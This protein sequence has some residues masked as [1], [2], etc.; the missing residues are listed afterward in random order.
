MNKAALFLIV[1]LLGCE[2]T[3]SEEI[4]QCNGSVVELLNDDQWV[5][6]YDCAEYTC[7]GQNK[8]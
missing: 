5:F 6:E 8:P 4:R 7:Q 3:E 2:E 1:P